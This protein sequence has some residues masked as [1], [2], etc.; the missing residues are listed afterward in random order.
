MPILLFV[1][2]SVSTSICLFIGLTDHLTNTWVN[3]QTTEWRK[4]TVYLSVCPSLYLVA[5]LSARRVLHM[6]VYQ[7]VSLPVSLCQFVYPS[8]RLC[9]S[10]FLVCL[11][12]RFVN[13][14]VCKYFRLAVH[15]SAE[16]SIRMSVKLLRR[17][18]TSVYEFVCFLS[19]LHLWVISV[20]LFIYLLVRTADCC[21]LSYFIAHLLPKMTHNRSKE[22]KE[23]TDC[24]SGMHAM[25]RTFNCLNCWS[26]ISHCS[27]CF[28]N[29]KYLPC[30]H[31]EIMG[32]C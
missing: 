15:L 30:E 6:H 28:M 9:F 17:V 1:L 18:C 20:L 32:D 3:R 7:F 13:L 31:S 24:I 12:V 19:V 23:M 27:Q 16:L 8:L 26:L 5:R 10:L 21:K 22:I 4:T 11:S 25:Q 2:L 29:V 14:S